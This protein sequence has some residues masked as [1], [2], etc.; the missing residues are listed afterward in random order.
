MNLLPPSRVG[1]INHGTLTRQGS[2]RDATSVWSPVTTLRSVARPTV[3]MPTPDWPQTVREQT[4]SVQGERHVPAPRDNSDCHELNPTW[5]EQVVDATD[6]LHNDTN[7][8]AELI[9]C[10]L[11]D[12][13]QLPELE[14]LVGGRNAT[15]GPGAPARRRP[16]DVTA[17]VV[18]HRPTRR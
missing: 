16:P 7:R 10:T 13:G 11:D 17:T 4:R 2:E 12:P 18:D 6:A 3:R 14:Y 5:R 8:G 15:P 1:G 9:R